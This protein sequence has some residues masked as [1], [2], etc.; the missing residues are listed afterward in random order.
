M[1]VSINHHQNGQSDRHLRCCDGHD[2]EHENLSLRLPP[3]RGESDHEQVHRIEH[4]FD[5]H[6]L[7][8]GVPSVNDPKRTDAEQGSG[9]VEVVVDGHDLLRDE[10]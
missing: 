4:Q 8:D 9:E 5:A 1:E 2:E 3:H 6:K 7:H 10:E